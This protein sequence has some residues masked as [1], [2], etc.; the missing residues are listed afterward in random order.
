MN[1]EDF[2]FGVLLV[3]LVII[4]FAMSLAT[5]A[6]FIAIIKMVLGF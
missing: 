4:V 2:C 3:S 1:F 6:L 5:V